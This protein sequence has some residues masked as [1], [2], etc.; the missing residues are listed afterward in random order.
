MA[1]L[2][3]NDLVTNKRLQEDAD[4]SYKPVL[5]VSVFDGLT[6]RDAV[7]DVQVNELRRQV[8]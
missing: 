7:R 1:D 3:V 8:H 6:R 5:H 2:N 4:K